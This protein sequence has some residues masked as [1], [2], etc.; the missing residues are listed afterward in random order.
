MSLFDFAK[1]ELDRLGGDESL[2]KL[3]HDVLDLIEF[4]DIQ[5]HS[6]KQRSHVANAVKRILEFKPITPLTGE[7]DEWNT[8]IGDQ[9]VQ[10]NKRCPA[11]FRKNFDN[12]TAW[13]INGV[14]FSK[15]GGNTWYASEDSNVLVKFPYTVPEVPERVIILE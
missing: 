7:D 9:S 8:P 6:G 2:T 10:N 15:D 12:S 5:G 14:L 11:V 4:F 13:Y 1:R 3:N